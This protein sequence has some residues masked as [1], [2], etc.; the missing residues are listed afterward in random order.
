MMNDDNTPFQESKTNSSQKLV[1]PQHW[2]FK[3]TWLIIFVY[4]A[5]WSF[6]KYF[7]RENIQASRDLLAQGLWVSRGVKLDNYKV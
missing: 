6:T 4:S 3:L 1:W 2:N 5:A 7:L